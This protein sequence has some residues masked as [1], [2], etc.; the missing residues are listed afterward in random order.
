MINRFGDNQNGEVRE[1]YIIKSFTAGLLP[2]VDHYGYLIT[3][4]VEAIDCFTVLKSPLQIMQDSLLHYGHDLNGATQAAK[5]AL[6]NIDMPPVKVYNNIYWF[7]IY[8]K[9][10]EHNIWIASNHGNLYKAKNRTETNLYIG[11]NHIITLELSQR[12]YEGKLNKA[13]TLE[14]IH[15]LRFQELYEETPH[16]TNAQIVREYQHPYYHYVQF[17]EKT[18]NEKPVKHKITLLKY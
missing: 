17:G 4:V 7:P 18:N 13:R 8:S 15:N 9:V 3:R 12:T 2:W 6:G 11:K 14:I 1:D 16:E 10:K 5:Q